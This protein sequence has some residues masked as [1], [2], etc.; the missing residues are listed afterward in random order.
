MSP[1]PGNGK[2]G[3]FVHSG[4]TDPQLPPPNGTFTDFFLALSIPAA[5]ASRCV[6]GN[7]FPVESQINLLLSLADG[8]AKLRCSRHTR[9]CHS[10]SLARESTLQV[11]IAVPARIEI[12]NRHRE[13]LAGRDAGNH[14]DAAAP[15]WSSPSRRGLRPESTFFPHDL[16]PLHSAQSVRHATFPVSAAN[17]L[18][19]PGSSSNASR[20]TRA[21]NME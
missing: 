10:S 1:L 12:G 20:T 19:W 8:I 16:P 7:L 17:V 6:G 11:V 18:R 21:D 2:T 14:L 15:R 5:I 3:K 9:W 4:F 13:S